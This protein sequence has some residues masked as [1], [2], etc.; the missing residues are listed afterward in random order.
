[1]HKFISIL[2]AAILLPALSFGAVP[3]APPAKTGQTASYAS[4]DDGDLEKGVAWP[5]PR[6]TDNNN[7]TVTDNMTGLIWLKN[8][9]SCN[10][11]LNGVVKVANEKPGSIV[12][13]TLIWPDAMSWT[14]ALASGVCG[15]SDGSTAGQWRLPNI[16]ELESLLDISRHNPPLPAGHPFTGVVLWYVWSSTSLS[17]S[18]SAAWRVSMVDGGIDYNVKTD[19]LNSSGYVWPVR[20]GQ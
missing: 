19:N 1:M 10:V 17:S 14:N 8:N 13:G 11:T 6:F 7:G 15:L 12:I 18:T 20:G 2:V 9:A 5:V 16:I 3:P 4:G